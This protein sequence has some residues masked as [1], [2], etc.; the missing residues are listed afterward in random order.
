MQRLARLVGCTGSMTVISALNRAVFADVR[1]TRGTR[2]LARS[3]QRIHRDQRV[4]AA[5]GLHDRWADMRYKDRYDIF[6][7]TGKI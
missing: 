3:E 2:E 6:M 7:R 5:G 4:A 1:T